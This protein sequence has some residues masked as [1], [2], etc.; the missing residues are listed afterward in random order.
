[1]GKTGFTVGASCMPQTEHG[2]YGQLG[3]EIGDGQGDRWHIHHVLAADLQY[4]FYLYGSV[5]K[6]YGPY[7]FHHDHY[8]NPV[9]ST[10][11]ALVDGKRGEQKLALFHSVLD[12]HHIS[13]EFEDFVD[14]FFDLGRKDSVDLFL[15]YPSE[16]RSANDLPVCRIELVAGRMLRSYRQGEKELHQK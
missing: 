13:P 12:R 11:K 4:A 10:I 15:V 6:L 5:G 2:N 14:V 9:A 1:M 16:L 7:H 8:R 3:N